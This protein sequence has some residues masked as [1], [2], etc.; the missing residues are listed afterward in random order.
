MDSVIGLGDDLVA[1]G[2]V[3][4]FLVLVGLGFNWV[5]VMLSIINNMKDV[6]PSGKEDTLR[7][8][9]MHITEYV[10]HHEFY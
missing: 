4:F 6:N 1:I 10:I 2:V 5:V 7:E 3:V 9:I 8:R